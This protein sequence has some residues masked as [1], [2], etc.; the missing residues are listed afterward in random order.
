MSVENKLLP[1]FINAKHPILKD[2]IHIE[3][4]NYRDLLSTLMKKSK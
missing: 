1:K 2:E 4:K 3:Y